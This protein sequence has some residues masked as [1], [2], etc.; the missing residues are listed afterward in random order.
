MMAGATFLAGASF[1]VE[2]IVTH[3]GYP[4]YFLKIPGVAKLIGGIAILQNRFRAIKGWAYP[5]YT[6]NLPEHQLRMH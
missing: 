4:F 2:A 3:L 6:L 1:N 5:W